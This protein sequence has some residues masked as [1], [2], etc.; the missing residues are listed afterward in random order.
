M[1]YYADVTII[2]AAIGGGDFTSLTAFEAFYDGL[3][4]SGTDGVRAR[5]KGTTDDSTG[6][7]FSD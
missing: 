5:M 1:A 2:P 4:L 6:I 3:N 7:Y